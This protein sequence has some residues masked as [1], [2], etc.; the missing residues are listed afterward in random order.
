[1]KKIIIIFLVFFFACGPTTKEKLL[2][3]DCTFRYED[4][5]ESKEYLEAFNDEEVL[6]D[7]EIALAYRDNLKSILNKNRN[8]IGNC[9]EVDSFEYPV[10]QETIA[11]DLYL[12]KLYTNVGYW[13]INVIDSS[14]IVNESGVETSRWDICNENIYSDECG[15]DYDPTT[16]FFWSYSNFFI[17]TREKITTWD[18]NSRVNL[19]NS[20]TPYPKELLPIMGSPVFEIVEMDQTFNCYIH[21]IP[22]MVYYIRNHGYPQ[23]LSIAENS[24]EQ[25]I[26]WPEVYWLCLKE[27]ISFPDEI[28]SGFNDF[29]F[30]DFLLGQ[31]PPVLRGDFGNRDPDPRY[32]SW[33]MWGPVNPERNSSDDL[34]KVKEY[35]ITKFYWWFDDGFN[36]LDLC[37]ETSFT[38]EID[39]NYI[40]LDKNS[41]R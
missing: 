22:S 21:P 18:K 8:F 12:E 20:G 39:Y 32:A 4:L 29:K 11:R 24:E 7:E 35:S 13:K 33:T 30:G 31:G 16:E 40:C 41:N 36:L 17:D 19:R 23:P 15:A 26:N 14:D 37:A 1:M 28:G 6:K 3:S 10:L 34:K 2:Q 5:L 27:N 38:Y 25:F 9:E